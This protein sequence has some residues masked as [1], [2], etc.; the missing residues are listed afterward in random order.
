MS[1]KYAEIGAID[2]P[3]ELDAAILAEAGRAAKTHSHLT[4]KR[5]WAVPLSVAATVMICFSLV[6][7]VLREAPVEIAT[8]QEIDALIPADVV[9]AAASEESFSSN[10]RPAVPAEKKESALAESLGPAAESPQALL[11]ETTQRLR[12]SSTD[13]SV[14]MRLT[15]TVLSPTHSIGVA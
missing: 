10:A 4:G 14:R 11:N 2:P 13:G 6:L 12:P 1:E 15:K 3:A 5:S 7:N 8:D 9:D